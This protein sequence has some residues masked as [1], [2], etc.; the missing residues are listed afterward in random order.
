MANFGLKDAFGYLEDCRPQ[1]LQV[2]IA[3]LKRFLQIFY[4]LC[5]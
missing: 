3:H 4:F 1:W 5:R 2:C